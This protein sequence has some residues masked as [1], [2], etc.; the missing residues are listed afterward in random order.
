MEETY[1]HWLTSQTPTKWWHDSADPDEIKFGIEH[2]AI[3]ATTNPVLVYASLKNKPEKWS[4]YLNEIPVDGKRTENLLKTVVQNTAKQFESI[5]EQNN[6]EAGLVCAQ[7]DPAMASNRDAMMDMA[8]RF[9]KWAPNI[10]VKLP[11][12]SAGLDVLEE[13]IAQGITIASTVSFTVPQVI[14]A[15]QRHKNGITRAKRNGITP[16]KCFAV[17]MIGRIDG[18][19]GE[20]AQDQKVDVTEADIKQA[21]LAIAKRAYSIYKK[22]AYEAKLMVAALRGT[23]HMEQLAGADLIMS[24]FP[25]YQHML[26]KPGIP[27]KMHIDEPI[28]SKVISKLEK[29]PEFVR[30]Y[31]PDGL[32]PQEFITYGVTQKT[33]SQF[34][35]AGWAL[36]DSIK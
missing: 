22:E 35:S 21:G 1:F 3:G 28:D 12:T 36:I 19:L 4:S 33:L 17:I 27:R 13:C 14:A 34:S 10:A 2:K 20:V 24:I 30:A 11:A 5:Y 29:I 23:Y 26:L 9:H 32:K 7:V 8:Q 31:E 15:A 18:Y 16:G 6:K 25:A